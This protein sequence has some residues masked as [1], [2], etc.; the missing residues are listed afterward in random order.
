MSFCKRCGRRIIP[1]EGPSNADILIVG[2]APTQF[3][4]Q[5]G[6][7][8]TGPGGDILRVELRRVGINLKQCRLTNLWLHPKTK[9]C[10]MHL[11]ELYE[12]MKG[13]KF[14]LLMGADAVTQ[15]TSENVSDVSGLRVDKFE[16]AKE[17][18]PSGSVV[19]ALFNPAIALHDKLGEIRFGLEKFGEEMNYVKY[20]A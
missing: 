19:Y 6:S 16:Y 7:L 1:P 9:D 8:W 15:F 13:R 11:D 12:E 10:E 18:L 17:M 5:G 20:T 4:I 14:I 2:D 3:D